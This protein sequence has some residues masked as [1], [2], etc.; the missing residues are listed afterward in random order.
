MLVVVLCVCIVLWLVRCLF[1]FTV[2]VLMFVLFC[3]CYVCFCSV[4][5]TV[6]CELFSVVVFLFV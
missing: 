5:F 3:A 1:V 2:I 4:G 6:L